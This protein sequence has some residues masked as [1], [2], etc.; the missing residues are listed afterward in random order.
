MIINKKTLA[1]VFFAGFIF[2]A[3]TSAPI[4][5]EKI[6]FVRENNIWVA[7]LDGSTPKQ[8]TFSGKMKDPANFFPNL[9]LSPDGQ[10]IAYSD[11]QDIYLLAT[12]GGEPVK[13][14]LPGM[15]RA[16]NPFFSSDGGKLLFLGTMN[17]NASEPQ[18]KASELETSSISMVELDSGKVK[19]IV[20]TT[21][22]PEMNSPYLLPSL[23]PSGGL[24]AVQDGATDYSGG[25]GILNEAG[26][27]F[28]H[29][30]SGTA[31]YTPYWRPLFSADGKKILCF[32]PATNVKGADTVYL[33]DI[34]RGTKKQVVK[35]LWPTFVD[36]GKAIVYERWNVHS[37]NRDKSSKSDLWL[38]ELREGAQPKKIIA[39]AASPAGQTLSK[40]QS[41]QPGIDTQ[42]LVGPEAVW[43]VPS[44]LFGKF[45]DCDEDLECLMKVMKQGGASPQA[46]AFTRMMKANCYLEKFTKTGKVDLA[47]V[48]FPSRANTNG[49]YVL[50]NGSPPMVSTENVE[51]FSI[52]I[53]KDPLYTSLSRKYRELGLWDPAVFKQMET[54]PDGGQRFIFAYA[55]IN[56]PHA[57]K[58]VG[59]VLVAF[60]FDGQ[61]RFL[62]SKLVRL[63]RENSE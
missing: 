33:V 40:V 24:I 5:A 7:N 42:L 26:K 63:T 58:Q 52:D 43:K 35:G 51:Q 36:S 23:S 60:D 8:L 38:L 34:D 17:A 31:D 41:T 29:F 10:R 2:L 25:F 39:N 12:G 15:K 20:V 32:S 45:T 13:L 30:P 57:G 56:G 19:N 28:F 1:V 22:N 16:E 48:F 14:N 54:L 53:T 11:M 9:A 3:M 49:A 46:M 4:Q 59:W 18:N 61:G 44:H 21:Y 50:V 47:Y 62:H 55:L 27:F 6:A 37:I